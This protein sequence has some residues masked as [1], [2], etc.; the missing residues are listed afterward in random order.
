MKLRKLALASA[1]PALL[2]A[3]SAANASVRPGSAGF[4]SSMDAPLAMSGQHQSLAV[5][6]ENDFRKN[7]AWLAALAA[8]FAGLGLYYA[9]QDG[10]VS[11]S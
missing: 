3:S 1:V 8:F 9:F 6:S 2:L 10:G 4:G 5:A 7:S 11:P